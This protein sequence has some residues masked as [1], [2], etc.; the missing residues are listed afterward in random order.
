MTPRVFARSCPIKT[1]TIIVDKRVFG[2]GESLAERIARELGLFIRDNLQY[3][4]S[5]EEVIV[6]YDR[7]QRQ[8]SSA[9]KLIFSSTVNNVEFRTVSPKDYRLFQ[10]ADLACTLELYE[11]KLKNKELGS[12]EIRFFD[13]ERNLRKNHLKLLK[14]LSY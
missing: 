14:K 4:Q 6:Y 3:F 7:G 12:S 10:V 13:G 1:K 5:F 11:Q 9:L 2:G 8:I